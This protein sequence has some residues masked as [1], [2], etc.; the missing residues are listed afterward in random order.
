MNE[1]ADIG[2]TVTL[3]AGVSFISISFDEGTVLPCSK[4]V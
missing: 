2:H 4:R 3:T 1:I